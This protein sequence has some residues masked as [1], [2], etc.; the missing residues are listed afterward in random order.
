MEPVPSAVTRTYP[1]RGP[2]QQFRFAEATAFS[3]LRCGASKKSKLIT[4]YRGDWAKRLCNG[5]Y[6]QLLSLYEVKAGTAA[7]DERAEELAGLLLS[8]VSQDAQREA[9]RLLLA[10]ETR[11]RSL[12]AESVRFIATADYVARHLHTEPGLEWSPATIGLC[13]AFEAEIVNRILRPLARLTAGVDLGEDRK[14]RDL[15]R[16]ATFCS[17]PNRKPP[18]LGTFAHFLRT[19]SQKPALQDTSTLARTFLRLSANWVGSQWIL[20]PQGLHFV[21]TTLTKDYRNRAAHT[22][23]LSAQ[24]YRQCREMLVGD[25][26][27]LWKL[28]VA[29]EE[30]K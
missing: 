16:V 29:L 4:I 15:S 12:S 11:T 2:L 7:D 5:C 17:E 1:P 30:H 9:E 23:E 6:G 26:G 28:V 19:V 18:E 14:D 13:K 25:K 27:A 24:D 22:D 3:C 8:L 20:E 21:L 10:A